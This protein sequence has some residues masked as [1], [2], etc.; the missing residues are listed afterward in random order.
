MPTTVCWRK[1]ERIVV[2]RWWRN[3]PAEVVFRSLLVEA[4]D[5]IAIPG[6][7]GG[8]KVVKEVEQIDRRL[9]G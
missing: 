8:D 9:I 3:G 2:R 7:E 5:V 1:S 4:M 6:F